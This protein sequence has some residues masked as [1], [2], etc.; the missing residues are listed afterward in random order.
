MWLTLLSQKTEHIDILSFLNDLRSNVDFLRPYEILERTL[1]NH[2]KRA[3]FSARLGLEVEESINALLEQARKFEKSHIPDLTSFILWMETDDVYIKRELE[4]ESTT[5]RVMTIHGS[6][7]L[8]SPIVILPD[9]SSKILR[10]V[11]YTHLTLPTK[12]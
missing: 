10:T 1:I 2:N 9:T 11:S 8:E 3:A 12:A 7:G 5:I 4:T 6:K